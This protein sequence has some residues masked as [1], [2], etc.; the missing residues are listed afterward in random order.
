MKNILMSI[1]V[2][3]G[4]LLTACKSRPPIAIDNSKTYEIAINKND[5]ET[6][7]D[8]IPVSKLIWN[9]KDEN[10]D[11][12]YES[13]LDKFCIQFERKPQRIVMIKDEASQEVLATIDKIKKFESNL[14]IR[15]D[16]DY[17]LKPINGKIT[18]LKNEIPIAKITGSKKQY[19]LE[20]SEAYY[21]NSILKSAIL[22]KHSE[23]LKM[24]G[25][26]D[27][28]IIMFLLLFGAM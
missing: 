3:F 12:I 16:G 9:K 8:S 25:D 14:S 4:L 24:K 5:Y 26:D 13:E 7:V 23:Y 2:V 15:R 11:A 1:A 17:I 19:K 18:V 10:C 21:N 22:Y 27:M 28:D 6:S 20:M